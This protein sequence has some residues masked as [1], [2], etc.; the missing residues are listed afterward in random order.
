[1]RTPFAHAQV[2]RERR[3]AEVLRT[4]YVEIGQAVDLI[5]LLNSVRLYICGGWNPAVDHASLIKF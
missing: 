5:D 1:V 3:E 2:P 4:E